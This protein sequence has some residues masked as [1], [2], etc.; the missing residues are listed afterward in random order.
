MKLQENSGMEGKFYEYVY[1]YYCVVFAGC[2]RTS[3]FPKY[4]TEHTGAYDGI[5]KGKFEGEEIKD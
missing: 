5:T 4:E 1:V 2:W 3:M